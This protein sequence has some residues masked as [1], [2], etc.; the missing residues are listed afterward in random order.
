MV[1]HPSEMSSALQL[2]ALAN[3][4]SSEKRLEL[5]RRISD[6]FAVESE[7]ASQSVQYLLGEIV[8]KLVDQIKTE[9][10]A[11]AAISLS[12]LDRL[13]EDLVKSLVSD[14]DI[15]VARPI[16]RDY[17]GLTSAILV[18]LASSASQTHLEAIAGR[19]AIGPDVTDV[20]V[21]RGNS[22]VVRTLASN[23]GARFSRFGMSAMVSKAA[24]DNQL[25]ELLVGRSDLSL[26]AVGQLL[27]LVS[28]QLAAKLRSSDLTFNATVVQEQVVSWVSDRKKNIAQVHRSIERIKG[29]SEKLDNVLTALMFERRLLDVATVIAGVAD[30]DRDYGFNLVTQGKVDNVVVLLRALAVSWPTAESILALRIDKLGSQLC[31]P[32][33]DQPMY[34]SVDILGAQRVMRFL[35]VRRTAMAQER[36]A[37]AS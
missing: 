3:E 4:R 34:E 33:V 31:G 35:K 21:Q 9:D 30:L 32:M 16:I 13:P 20:V 17:R 28:Q 6:S 22:E 36:A 18:N 2:F 19:D 14:D 25:Q 1:P 23:Q 26:E 10:R 8:T 11:E 12:K 15:A 24:E 27:P 7:S 37:V 29:G 5:L